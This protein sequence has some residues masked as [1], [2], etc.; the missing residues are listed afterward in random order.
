MIDNIP[1]LVVLFV[2]NLVL[3]LSATDEWVRCINV[4]SAGMAFGVI[5]AATTWG[6]A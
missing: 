5:I 6:A 3:A 1:M 2:F 4:F